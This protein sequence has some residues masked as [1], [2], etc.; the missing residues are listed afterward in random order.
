M[1]SKSPIIRPITSTVPGIS[2]RNFGGGEGF[3]GELTN[4]AYE[5][6]GTASSNLICDVAIPVGRSRRRGRLLVSRAQIKERTFHL[7]I[8]VQQRLHL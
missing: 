1:E 5:Y 3:G 2:T 8:V 4:R 7:Y 6:H